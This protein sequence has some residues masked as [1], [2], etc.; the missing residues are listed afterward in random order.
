MAIT[1]VTPNEIDLSGSVFGGTEQIFWV[2]GTTI[3]TNYTVPANTN[4]GTFGP[5]TIAN[6]VTVTVSNTSTWTVV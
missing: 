6:N 2:N 5:V 1:K 3:T 4:A